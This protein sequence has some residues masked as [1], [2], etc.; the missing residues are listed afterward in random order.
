MYVSLSKPVN[1]SAVNW[2]VLF[3]SVQEQGCVP[4]SSHQDISSEKA[5][6]RDMYLDLSHVKTAVLN[7]STTPLITVLYCDVLNIPDNM[8]WLIDDGALI[9]NARMILSG[10]GVSIN[11]DLRSNAKN[12]FL[13]FTRNVSAPMTI[14]AVTEA[15]GTPETKTFTIDTAPKSGGWLF[16]M[17][18]GQPTKTAL[19]PAQGRAM[20]PTDDFSNAMM[21]EF[22][23][24]SLLYDQY[25]DIA[26]DMMLWIKDL[27]SN[28]SDLIDVFLRASSMVSLL[29]AQINAKTNGCAFVP[30][31]SKSV[32]EEQA[33]AFVAEARQYESDYMS[34]STQKVLTDNDLKLAKTLLD[35]KVYEA[36]YVSKLLEQA[37]SNYDNASSAVAAANKS[38]TAAQMRAKMVQIDFEKVGIP[39]WKR[40]QILKAVIDL[41]TALVSFGVGIGEMFVGDAAG[42]AQAAGAALN[43][44]ESVAKAAKTGT[45]MAKT[46][47]E[48]EKSMKELLKLVKAL[49]KI[50]KL[51]DKLVTASKQMDKASSYAAEIADMDIDT[52]G[53][54]ISATSQWELYKLSADAT[55]ED[56]V[57]KGIGYASDLKLSIDQLVVYGQALASAQL[58][59]I[60]AGQE[61]AQVKMQMEMEQQQ[62]AKL[63][64][65]VDSLKAGDTLI[66]ANMQ[67]FYQRYIDAK[68]ALFAALKGYQASY[69]FWALNHSS[70]QA[71]IIDNV[72][73]VATGL[74]DITAI[75]L[76]NASALKK[77]NP[78]P[79][80]MAQ[81]TFEI[82]DVDVL[83][84]LKENKEASWSVPLNTSAF[85][86]LSRVRLTRVRVWLEG[87]SNGSEFA[88]SVT[89]KNNGNFRDRLGATEYQFTSNPLKR[90]FEY[91]V[92]P[93]D[94]GSPD[95]RFD[96][97]EYG[98]VEIDGSVDH[99]VS[100]AYFEPTPFGEWHVTVKSTVDLSNLKKV[101]ME[102][103]GSVIA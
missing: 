102:F 31:L 7:S 72:N 74:H 55:L 103:A 45:E 63:Q 56:P 2:P 32:Y 29:S 90:A 30:Y 100:Y 53:T 59:A 24:G 16:S 98:Y 13:L 8:T 35:N 61:L 39:E 64:Q 50:Y 12:L 65:Y 84:K 34:L 5:V 54:D 19:S 15:K 49:D 86:G 27:C 40:E 18:E 58:A 60:K 21:T 41:T 3:N 9:I 73:S 70:V 62:Q 82:D 79:Q 26:L 97:G 66:A 95:W 23:Y 75:Q 25:P 87:V 22:I 14:L 48:A 51:V 33:S 36:G 6:F 94:K 47:K 101:I 37:Q 42:G 17:H 81:K 11:L 76:D 44:A 20:T 93:V 38:F 46:A 80:T 1:S 99:E 43:G 10:H 68:S 4:G 67:A 28:N 57:E 52:A 91:K 78:P 77:F 88:V 92:S 96:N 83:K 89:I 69:F 85:G 71:K